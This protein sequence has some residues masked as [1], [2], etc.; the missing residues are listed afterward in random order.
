MSVNTFAPAGTA[1]RIPGT[2]TGVV[3]DPKIKLSYVIVRGS[4][5]RLEVQEACTDAQISW[6]TD[7]VT[8]LSLTFADPEF[9]IWRTAQFAKNTLVIY[10]EPPSPDIRLRIASINLDGGPAGTG[11]FTVNCRSEGVWLLKRRQG[12]LIMPKKSP[13]DFVVAECKAVGLKVVAQPSPT[14][15]QIMRDVPTEGDASRGASRPSSWTTFQR[16]A[17]ELGYYVFEFGGTIYF[18]TPSWL[19]KRPGDPLTVSVPFVKEGLDERYAALNIPSISMSEDAEVP[20][21]ITGIQ[22]HRSRFY[23]VRPGKNLHLRGLHPFI[24]HYLITSVSMPLLGTGP[25]DLSARTP[26]DPPPQP[27]ESTTQAD[28][29]FAE[30]SSSS[31]GGAAG[32]QSGGG[33]NANDFVTVAMQQGNAR[34]VFGAEANVKNNSP[35]AFDC[36]ELIEWA[37]GRI[38]IKFVDGSA[39]Q[40]AKCRAISVQQAIRTRGALLYKPGHIGISLGDGRTMEA[41]NSKAGVGVFRASDIA[42]TRG[43][44]VPGLNY[45]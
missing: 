16:L 3:T 2:N 19:M 30:T 24:A 35:D 15:T 13:T 31:A 28:G 41:R 4:T 34:Y 17:S 7:E 43:G 38:G 9:R 21:E 22:L 11:G 10:R 23:E 27:P 18:G 6:S 42:W 33:K 40:I 26:I 45:G 8:Q 36:S 29:A 25:I 44:L 14:R 12:P 5:L 1:T 20:V 39:N 32:K 37:L